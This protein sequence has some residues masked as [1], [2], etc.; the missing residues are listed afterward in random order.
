MQI[1]FGEDHTIQGASIFSYLLEKSRVVSVGPNERTYHAFYALT[2]SKQYG[3]RD[4]Q[5]YAYLRQSGC[6]TAANIDDASY[7]KEINTSM[8]QIGFSQDEQDK[9]WM[10]IAVILD[11]GNLEFDDKYHQ[12]H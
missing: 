9:V 11:L 12:I 7:F 3:V 8:Q 5:S 1:F 4:P 10:V 2:A 6:Y